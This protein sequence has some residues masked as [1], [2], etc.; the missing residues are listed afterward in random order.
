MKTIFATLSIALMSTLSVAP[1]S[2]ETVD[3]KVFSCQELTSAI[4]SKDKDDQFG[5]SAILYW[6]HGYL[7]TEEQGTVMDFGNMMKSFEKTAE[8]C[9]KNPNIGVLTAGQKFMGENEPAA[10]TDA[11]DLAI[12]TCEKI[13][14]SDRS[15]EKGLGQI[16]MWLAGFHAS[17]DGDTLIDFNK[18]EEE[19]TSIGSYCS[20]NQ[21]VGFYTASEKFM[22]SDEDDD[23]DDSSEE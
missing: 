3:A 15:D 16:M 5:A 18:L 22:G 23:E 2:A 20:D 17:D 7:A 6:I 19:A 8:F 11:V 21:Q 4:A 14:N 10:G 1:A 13:V 9:G 12:M